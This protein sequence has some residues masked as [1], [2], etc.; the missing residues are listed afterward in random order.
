MQYLLGYYLYVHRLNLILVD[1]NMTY[2]L[3][4]DS[5]KNIFESIK[6]L[7]YI[8]TFKVFIYIYFKF[9][10][11]FLIIKHKSHN[12]QYVTLCGILSK[13]LVGASMYI[14][15]LI[16]KARWYEGWTLLYFLQTCLW[17][18]DPLLE[19]IWVWSRMW[20]GIW[21]WLIRCYDY[22]SNC[23]IIT[24]RV[25]RHVAWLGMWKLICH[26]GSII[27]W[28]FTWCIGWLDYW[29]RRKTF[30]WIANGNY[31]RIPAWISK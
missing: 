9:V 28:S 2:F 14:F 11:W 25:N 27:G 24:R 21:T 13:S 19:S 1:L 3:P 26:M 10:T 20:S 8:I 5:N 12:T 22:G 15:N 17:F 4:K 18:L 23:W 6:Y 31:T 16:T 30:G 29:Y 7:Y